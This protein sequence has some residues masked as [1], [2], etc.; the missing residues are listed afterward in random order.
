MPAGSALLASR[1]ALARCCAFGA[2]AR[3]H[4]DASGLGVRLRSNPDKLARLG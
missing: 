3:V 2:F 4:T 1:S